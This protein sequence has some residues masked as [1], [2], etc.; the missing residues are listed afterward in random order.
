ML[1]LAAG[2][3]DGG[4]WPAQA[5]AIALIA[6]VLLAVSLVTAPRDRGST[7]VIVSLLVL[8]AWWWIR[9]ATCGGGADFLPLGA[10]MLAF[11][12][13]FAAT[14]AL[15]G[16][17]RQWAALAMAG[18]GATVSLT[19]FVGLIGR[20]SPLALPAQGL[21]RLSASLTYADAAGLACAVCL[22]LALGCTR[23]PMLVRVIVC[24]NVAGVVATQS[25][26]AAAAL[27]CGCLLVP[28]TRYKEMALPLAAGVALGVAAVASSPQRSAVPWLGAVLVIAVAL[29]LLNL[30]LRLRVLRGTHAQVAASALAVAGF[31]VAALLVHHEI[32]LRAL[33]PSDQDRSAEWT[34]AFH[35]WTSAPLVGVGP[36]RLLALGANDGSWAHFAHNEYLQITADAGLVGLALVGLTGASL[37]GTLRRT[38]PLSSA[39]VACLVC[40][41]VGG[42]FDFSW[43]LPALG[44]LGGWCA[45]LATQ[46]TLQGDGQ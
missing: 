4:F 31:A 43:H 13:A 15:R 12:A 16:D 37:G 46:G 5:A 3:R 28:W 36:D 18:L 10:S 23:A 29:A 45:G 19:G 22:L 30:S 27:A 40:W 8:T 21:W 42:L 9:S 24:L 1:T 44:L 17:A 26:G 20:W 32:G 38:G 39:A 14:R 6:V 33:A 41:A 7:F 11:A 35:Q 25:R 34:A 2:W